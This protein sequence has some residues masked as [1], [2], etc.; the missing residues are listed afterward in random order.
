MLSIHVFRWFTNHSLGGRGPRGFEVAWSTNIT[1]S[2]IGFVN[3]PVRACMVGGT[4]TEGRRAT[5]A[6]Q[7][8][9]KRKRKKE[10]KKK[11]GGG[12]AP[13]SCRRESGCGGWVGVDGSF[14]TP[15]LLYSGNLAT[16]VP[17]GSLARYLVIVS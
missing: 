11:K 10:K 14:F 16:I 4:E 15:V 1:L 13:A 12:V 6:G 17:G 8:K 9:K 7:K 2:N 5:K 3:S